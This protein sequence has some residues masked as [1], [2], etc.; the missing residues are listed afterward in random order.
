LHAAKFG[1]THAGPFEPARARERRRMLGSRYSRGPCKGEEEE[2][3]ARVGQARVRTREEENARA[4]LLARR[5]Q[6]E[7]E[8]KP[9]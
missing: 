4:G 9:A 3:P 2:K 8:E 7:E 1:D 6:E 5:V